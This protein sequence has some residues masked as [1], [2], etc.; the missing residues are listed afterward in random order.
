VVESDADSWLAMALGTATF[1][2]LSAAGRVRAS[3]ERSDLSTL[4]P[5][6]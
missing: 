5:L 1:A 2:E 4:L 6:T 3:G